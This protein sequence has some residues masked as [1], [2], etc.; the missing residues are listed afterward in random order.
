L[1]QQQTTANDGLPRHFGEQLKHFQTNTSRNYHRI[2]QNW[3]AELTI[4]YFY[5]EIMRARE[6]CITTLLYRAEVRQKDLHVC[7]KTRLDPFS[8]F[9]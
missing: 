5:R 2:A 4:I 8:S 6:Y 9:S 3:H 7:F 1:Q